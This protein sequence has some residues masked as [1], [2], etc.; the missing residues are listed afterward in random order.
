MGPSLTNAQSN[1]RQQLQ[2]WVQDA[3]QFIDQVDAFIQHSQYGFIVTE[4]NQ[5]YN[6]LQQ[7]RPV[8][9]R[10]RASNEDPQWE[11]PNN[12]N[13][14]PASSGDVSIFVLGIIVGALLI[15]ILMGRA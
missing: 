9:D 12:A 4:F 5:I 13:D 1:D 8:V 10:L 7:M 14:N 3:R 2:H 15:Y 11:L 6:S